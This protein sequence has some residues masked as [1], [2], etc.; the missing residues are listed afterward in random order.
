VEPGTNPGFLFQ[1]NTMRDALVAGLTLNYL[2][3][4]CDRIEMANIAQTVNVLQALIFTDGE[5]M[6]L[7]PT[8]HI[9]DM[10]KVHQDAILLPLDMESP[11]YSLGDQSLSSVQA[12]ASRSKEGKI[13][14]SLVNIDPEEVQKVIIN[15][16]GTVDKSVSGTILSGSAINSHNTFENP[17][18]IV[19]EKFSG[20]IVRGDQIALDLPAHSVLVLEIL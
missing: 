8:Y 1:Q 4:R 17:K 15:L 13:H 12:S 11:L 2:N 10:Y 5:K 7:T 18:N 19:P 6:L 14:I 20:L 16:K 3:E 9:Y